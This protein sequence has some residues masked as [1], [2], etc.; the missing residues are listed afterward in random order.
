[1][2]S[3]TRPTWP[4]HPKILA[5]QRK[6]DY[7]SRCDQCGGLLCDQCHMCSTDKCWE[8]GNFRNEGKVTTDKGG[9]TMHRSCR[10]DWDMM[11]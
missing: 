10:E 11:W 9:S 1:M 4:P 5:A 7:R 8:S 3:T 6:G 2:T